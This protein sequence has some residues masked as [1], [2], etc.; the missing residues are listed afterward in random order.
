MEPDLEKVDISN[1][2]MRYQ[3][4]GSRVLTG[5]TAIPDNLIKNTLEASVFKPKQQKVFKNLRTSL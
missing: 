1:Y 4:I 5:N 2:K 3:K